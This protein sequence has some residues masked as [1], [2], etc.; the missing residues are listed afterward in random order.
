MSLRFP[1]GNRRNPFNFGSSRPGFGANSGFGSGSGPGSGF[2]SGGSGKGRGDS[3]AGGGA[4]DDSNIFKSLW[5]SYNK[6]LEKNP[7]ATKAVT[8]LIGF[9]LGDLLAQKF[10]GDKEA[11]LDYGRLARMA[12]FGLLL[13]GPTGHYFYGALDRLIVGT[14]PLQVAAKVAVDQLCWAPIFTV[15]FFTYLGAVERKKVKDIKEKIQNDTWDGVTA[16]WK[17]SL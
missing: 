15:M 16:S 13:H 7:I 1:G 17:V 12:T 14:G 2:G 3:E 5:H 9:L 8:S 10:L 11:D 4:S 6:C